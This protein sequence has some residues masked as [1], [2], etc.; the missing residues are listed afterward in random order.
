MSQLF[1]AGGPLFMGL[2]T[3]VLVAVISLFVYF[4]V[5]SEHQ[6]DISWVKEV[7]LFGLILGVFGQLKGLYNAMDAISQIESVSPAMLAGG[8]KVSLI[9]TMYGAVIALIG[10][11]LYF[12]LKKINTNKSS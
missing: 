3:L 4:I 6:H 2:L 11:A 10:Y 8:L 9:T 7:G 5:K 12:V 1:Y